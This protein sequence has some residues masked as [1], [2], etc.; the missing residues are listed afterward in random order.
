MREGNNDS[1]GRMKE[2]IGGINNV[3]NEMQEKI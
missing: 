1:Q 2:K 3:G